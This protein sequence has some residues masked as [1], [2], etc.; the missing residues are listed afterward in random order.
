MSMIN[1]RACKK[2]LNALVIAA[3]A[4]LLH[5]C[6]HGNDSKGEDVAALK[7]ELA[8]LKQTTES[9]CAEK[10]QFDSLYGRWRGMSHGFM[11]WDEA[12]KKATCQCSASPERPEDCQALPGSGSSFAMVDDNAMGSGLEGL[13]HRARPGSKRGLAQAAL[14][15]QEEGEE[16]S[17]GHGSA[18]LEVAVRSGGRSSSGSK[19]SP[20]ETVTNFCDVPGLQE[21]HGQDSEEDLEGSDAARDLESKILGDVARELET[22]NVDKMAKEIFTFYVCARW[23]PDDTFWQLA[24]QEL[25]MQF[26]EAQLSEP[27]A[28]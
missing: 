27:E 1:S 28:E 5:G 21:M 2:V 25:P 8:A 18:A 19:G 4:L 13:H 7:E 12:E 10:C 3:V 23:A 24:E 16:E 6:G 22:N 14:I 11:C 20:R 9:S 26:A 17:P 15:A